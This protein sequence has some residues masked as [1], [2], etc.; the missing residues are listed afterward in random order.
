[1]GYFSRI[2][3]TEGP[4]GATAKWEGDGRFETLVVGESHYQDA[5]EAI[6]GPR[7]EEGEDREVTATLIC[8]DANSFDAN[9]V[10]VDIDGRTVGH[11][12]RDSA[13]LYRAHLREKGFGK[14]PATCTARITGGWARGPR[15]AGHYGVAPDVLS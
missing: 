5:L 15:G 11:L 14:S 9:A 8:D 13:A 2:F 12:S 4:S 10:R 1:M 6:C 3:G 7:C